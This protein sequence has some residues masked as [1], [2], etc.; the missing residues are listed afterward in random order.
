MDSLPFTE[1]L[2]A[3]KKAIDSDIQAYSTHI[4][5]TTGGQ[6]GE[7]ARA[8]TDAYLDML[9]RGGKRIRGALVMAGYEMCGGTDRHMITRAATAIE[10][11]HAY[12]LIID[13]IQDRSKLRRGKPTVHEMLAAYHR[14]NNL[15]GDSSHVG[16]ALALNA[17]LTGGH[18]A[19][20]LLAG[21]SVDA[22]LR[23]KAIGIVNATMITT[24]HGQT[25][26]IIN[27]VAPEVSEE[28][29]KHALEWK[30]AHYTVLNPLCV[31]MVLAGAGC[32]D[33]NA[34]RE[35]ALHTGRA[36]QITDDIIG[37][38][39]DDLKTGKN[40]KDDIR[41]G[42]RTLL[43]A[44]ALRHA[45]AKD[46]KLLL[47]CLGNDALTDEGFAA[48]RHILTSC[49]ALESAR[50]M[51]AGHAEQAVRSLEQ[52]QSRWKPETVAFLRGLTAGLLGRAA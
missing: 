8:V 9:G 12:I 13:D 5:Q 2:A 37:V 30:T 1:Q 16:A 35:Y 11:I 32:E 18:A 10:M 48:C 41:E 44:Y 36:F 40:A 24:A 27:E 28:D 20:V 31:G 7:H 15:K 38:F 19:Q 47:S 50:A 34:I 49:G 39:G 14:N 42:K 33:T 21:L 51:A 23:M 3:Y 26:D 17:A 45:S 6:Y 4:H 43:I 46:K 52:Y 22:E 25:T 29:I